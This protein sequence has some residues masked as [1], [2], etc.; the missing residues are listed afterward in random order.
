MTTTTPTPHPTSAELG[1]LRIL[2]HLGPADAKQV[3]EAL[4]LERADAS[5]ATVLRQ[6]QLMHGKG[7]LTRD[8]SQRPQR[9]APALAQAQEKIQTSLLKDLISKVFS[10]SGKALVLA[11]LKE[12]ISADERAEIEKILRRK[13]NAES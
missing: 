5:Y 12:H 11:A 6:L 4:S 9:Y 13:D 8:E 1:L 2:W 7:M 3:Y 10:G